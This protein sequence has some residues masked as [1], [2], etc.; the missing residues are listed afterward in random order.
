MGDKTILWHIKITS[1]IKFCVPKIELYWNTTML[2]HG[3]FLWC[4]GHS[5]A[6]P[7]K[8]KIFP[9]WPFSENFA[10]SW[11]VPP[12]TSVNKVEKEKRKEGPLSVQF[13]SG[14]WGRERERM[15]EACRWEDWLWMCSSRYWVYKDRGAGGLSF[16]KVETH[17][18]VTNRKG[19]LWYWGP[20]E[21]LQVLEYFS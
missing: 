14:E 1:N 11:A 5:D 6:W 12:E 3:Y 18:Q 21:I 2:T 4:S 7:R 9:I 15:S 10:A 8:L 16:S 17:T 19:T 13:H 20:V